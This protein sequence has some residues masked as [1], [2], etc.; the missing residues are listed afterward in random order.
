MPSTFFWGI[1]HGAAGGTPERGNTSTT[2]VGNCS[3]INADNSTTAFTSS[4]ITAGNNSFIRYHWGLF[5]G[6]FN[7]VNTVKFNHVSGALNAGIT[8]KFR[9]SGSGWYATPTATT[10]S[11]LIHDLTNTGLAASTGVAVLVGITGPFADGKAAT[12][13]TTPSYTEYLTLQLV[14]AS[15]TAAGN[16]TSAGNYAMQLAWNEN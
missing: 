12:T 14:T 1:D 9:P 3:L 2:G 10:L 8:L 13:T 15:T 11:T 5:S 7:E 4:T 6:S 16:S